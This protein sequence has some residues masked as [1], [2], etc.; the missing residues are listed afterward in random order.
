MV[1]LAVDKGGCA[2]LPPSG[3]CPRAGLLTL[4]V[5]ARNMA[6]SGACRP[7]KFSMPTARSTQA[8]TYR[9]ALEG[10][11][12]FERGMLA[13]FF[14]LAESRTPAY[15]LAS[16]TLLSNEIASTVEFRFR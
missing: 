16:D 10:F 7:R 14:R 13:S 11:S 8:R 5:V 1:V 9:V 15:V 3:R 2:I 12:E 6:A 4:C